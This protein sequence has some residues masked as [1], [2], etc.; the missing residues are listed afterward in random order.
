MKEPHNGIVIRNRVDPTGLT[1]P[2][3]RMEGSYGYDKEGE[4]GFNKDDDSCSYCGSLNPNTFMARLEAGDIELSPTDKNY[5]VYV[6]NNEGIS[7]KQTY[8]IDED[9]ESYEDHHLWIYTTRETEQHKF[10]FQHLSAE[11]KTRFLVLHN[12]GKIKFGYPGHFYTTPYFA[13]KD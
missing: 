8:R 11:Q 5:K 10:Y 2:R 12:T 13:R 9:G 1:C 3:R 7:F 6:H 4:D